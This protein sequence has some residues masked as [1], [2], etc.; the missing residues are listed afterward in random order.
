MKANEK[1]PAQRLRF[2][3]LLAVA[4]GLK[5]APAWA[6]LV[7]GELTRTFESFGISVAGTY[8]DDILI[9]ASTREQCQKAR[10]LAINITSSLGLPFNDKGAG[11]SQRIQYLGVVISTTDCSMRV[12]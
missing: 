9:R 8:I 12:S 5:S 6:S 10:D 11:P 3:Q 7:S 1:K 2:R 4:F